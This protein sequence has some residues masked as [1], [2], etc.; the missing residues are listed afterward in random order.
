MNPTEN[1][2]SVNDGIA[3][4]RELR[5]KEKVGKSL[6]WN[7]KENSALSHAA[8]KA[9]L[10]PTTGSSMNNAEKARRIRAAFIK[11]PLRPKEACTT[12]DKGD[13]DHRRWDGRSARAVLGQWEIIR[14]ECTK[15]HACVK[16]IGRAQLTGNPSE[17]DQ[18]RCAS[19][20]YS[21]GSRA[22]SHLYDC[23][24]NKDYHVKKPFRFM[25]AY[26]VLSGSE[27]ML[28]AF[29]VTEEGASKVL[30]PE[31][32]KTA[33]KRKAEEIAKALNS[34]EEDVGQSVKR[35][36][37][38][39]EENIKSRK[40]TTQLKLQ[41]ERERME[42]DMAK[43]L[44]GPGS[45][46]TSEERRTI[47]GLL[48]RRLMNRLLAPGEKNIV[49]QQRR[50]EVDDEARADANCAST[51]LQISAVSVKSEHGCGAQNED[52]DIGH[53]AG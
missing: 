2:P 32:V 43:T 44:L 33:K 27:T 51:L 24:R 31:G 23:I 16:R 12:D 14:R 4:E 49:P 52:S 1:T 30:R 6:V 35:I 45:D 36:Q 47:S 34:K 40:A 50:G 37:Q 41:Y 39:I 28:E 53:G 46:A 8:Q 3:Q 26:K 38:M 19:L 20:L 18:L 5:R 29:V 17:E 15:Y 48:K 42:W 10:D 9:L 22:M 13:L 7:E 11:D 25:S 21:D